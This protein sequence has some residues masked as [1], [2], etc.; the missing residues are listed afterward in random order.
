MHVTVPVT[1][2]VAGDNLTIGFLM[3]HSD[4]LKLEDAPTNIHG[5]EIDST[6]E[7]FL[8]GLKEIGILAA[9][10]DGG[11]SF[12]VIDACIGYIAN[13]IKVVLELPFESEY[14]SD[15]MVIEAM[16]TQFDISVLPPEVSEDDHEAWEAYKN[17]L[18]D[19]TRSWINQP[20][21]KQMVYPISGFMGYMV[22][23]VF[24][25][26]PKEISTDSYIKSVFVDTIPLK[27]M[28]KIKDDIRVVIYECFGGKE[29]FEKYAHSLANE[30]LE[31][32]PL[33]T[34]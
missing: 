5:V 17:K 24:N 13:D 20:N 33:K 28:D 25:F 27:I 14:P 9:F 12:D 19:F 30:V 29:D 21:N 32:Y 31:S 1:E 11:L 7:S 26:R 34:S 3:K 15:S 4:L 16:S 10:E 22:G 6:P 18:L 2:V 8:L 23:E